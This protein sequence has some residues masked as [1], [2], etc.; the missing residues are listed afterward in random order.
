MLFCKRIPELGALEK[1][2]EFSKLLDSKLSQ[3]I[4]HFDEI[5]YKQIN[6]RLFLEKSHRIL[7][8]DF[9]SEC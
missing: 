2:T 6:H 1:Q 7:P 3:S 4:L 8:P 5:S 9:I